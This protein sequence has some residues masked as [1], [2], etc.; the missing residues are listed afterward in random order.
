MKK[1]F[2]LELE[3]DETV[4]NG[5]DSNLLTSLGISHER[6]DELL[7][8]CINRENALREEGAEYLN[9]LDEV[10]RL[11]DEN[12]LTGNEVLFFIANGYTSMMHARRIKERTL[13]EL[14]SN[15]VNSDEVDDE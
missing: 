11:L 8:L 1:T 2:V 13:M 7:M 5:A 9:S 15:M 12:A 6:G 3:L 10:V 14:L 4:Q